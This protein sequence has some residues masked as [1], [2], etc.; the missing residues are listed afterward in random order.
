MD[1]KLQCSICNCEGFKLDTIQANTEE[2]TIFLLG[3]CP[4]CNRFVRISLNETIKEAL[5]DGSDT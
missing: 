5:N 3:E 1:I 4:Y 2:G